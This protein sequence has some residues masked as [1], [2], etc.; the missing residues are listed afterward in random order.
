MRIVIAQRSFLTNK[1]LTFSLIRRRHF[2]ETSY[3]IR[4]LTKL[5][6]AHI[7]MPLPR[8]LKCFH[9][10]WLGFKQFNNFIW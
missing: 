6:H 1:T 10:A 7:M 3:V 4:M 2:G 5:N 8:Q 9:F